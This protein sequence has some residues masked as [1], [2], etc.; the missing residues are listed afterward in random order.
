[1]WKITG[2]FLAAAA[3]A[4]AVQPISAVSLDPQQAVDLPVSRE[5]T[6]V[7]FPG[8]ITAVAGA[9]ML[10]EGGRGPVEIEE[11]ALVRFHVTHAPG[12]NFIL[13]RSLQPE[14]T[15]RLTVIYEGSAYV[16]QLHSV[17]NDS[18]ASVI[19]KRADA[20]TAI[21]VDAPPEPVKFS[22]RIG[23]SLLDRARAYPVL[24]KSL[25]KAVEGVTLR[26]QNRKVELTDLE[27]TV[28]EVY[29]FSKEDAV[30][31]LLRLKNTT[32]SV[33]D[34]V[35]SSFAARVAQERFEQ[36]I[37]NGPRTLAPGE[38]ADA[39]FAIV[40]LPDGTRNDLSADNAFTILINSARRET[41]V[42]AL[43][44]PPSSTEATHP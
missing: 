16:I 30:V 35:P 10:I 1:M 34:L 38:S 36:S 37:A 7:M 18:V 39:E 44:T 5:I 19:F 8:A 25:P 43:A 20:Q 24:V 42:A 13:V 23:L 28:Q 15:A 33:L 11:G 27:I 22:P 40:G 41:K 31:F 29:R 26:A 4:W 3:S 2:L 21:R 17:E 32:D 12:S 14:A 9:D 6:T